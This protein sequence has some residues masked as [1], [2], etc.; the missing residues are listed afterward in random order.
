MLGCATLDPGCSTLDP[1]P[2]L[3]NPGPWLRNPGPWLRNPGPWLLNPGPWTLAAQPW[4][5]AAQPWTLAGHPRA[6]PRAYQLDKPVL[7]LLA[8]GLDRN[9]GPSRH[10]ALNVLH[11][12]NRQ[13]GAVLRP[14]RQQ[15]LV[16]RLPPL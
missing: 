7:L 3:L 16:V 9:A 12:D 6:Q 13:A 5:L 11:A 1:G 15:R 4:T 8:H 10:H 14:A 2:W